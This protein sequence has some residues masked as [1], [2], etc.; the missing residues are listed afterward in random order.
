MS[1]FKRFPIVT[2]F[3]LAFALDWAISI[4]LGVFAIENPPLKLVAEFAPTIAAFLITWA[5][6]GGEGV[7]MFLSRMRRW[8][9]SAWWYVLIVLGPVAIELVTSG[10]YALYGGRVQFVFPGLGIA[11]LFSRRKPSQRFTFGFGKVEDL[12]GIAIVMIII[13][14][15]FVAAYVSVDRLLHP[16]NIG[17]LG[18]VA[19]ASIIGFIGN[20]G[21]AIF[22]I[23][24]GKEIGSAAVP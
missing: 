8:R 19:A 7:R 17:F 18:A 12:A 24:V 9:V 3:V 4:P 20:E 21:V 14:S 11:F 10:L 13:F 22:R 15:G 1:L 23:K 6:Y 5:A 2:F 16:H